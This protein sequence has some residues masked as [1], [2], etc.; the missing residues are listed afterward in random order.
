LERSK[1]TW[2][3]RNILE[4]WDQKRV[5]IGTGLA[6]FTHDGFADRLYVF[7][8]LCQT[9]FGLAFVQVG[10]FK[11]LF[12]GTLAFFQVPSS[13]VAGRVGPFRLLVAGTL[14]T[15]AVVATLP[16]AFALRG[17]MVH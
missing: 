14:L 12:S 11:M 4:V 6:H 3:S 1:G 7:F 9:Q 2:L 5:I 17:K 13:Y 16:F 15:S 8:P 10:L